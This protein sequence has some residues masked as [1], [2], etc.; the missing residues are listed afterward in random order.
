CILDIFKIPHHD[1]VREGCEFCSYLNGEKFF[2]TSFVL[3]FAFPVLLILE[4]LFQ[5][6]DPYEKGY[7]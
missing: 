2:L 6:G 3:A 7:K 1:V 5:L 4:A